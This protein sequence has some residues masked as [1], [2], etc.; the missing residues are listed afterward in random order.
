MSALL[1]AHAI[2]KRFAGLVALDEVDI[3]VEHGERLGLIGPNGAGKT[4]FF[5]CLLGVLPID[6]GPSRWHPP[7]GGRTEWWPGR[8]R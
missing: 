3:E 5:N 1:Q 6:A 7:D 8:S 2:S 4:T